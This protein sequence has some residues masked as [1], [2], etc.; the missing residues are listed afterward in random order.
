MENIHEAVAQF[1]F[2]LGVVRSGVLHA[3]LAP[4]DIVCVL[5][6]QRRDRPETAG[7]HETDGL[8]KDRW[9]GEMCYSK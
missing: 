6:L 8:S 3:A 4:L 9:P 2:S 7:N 5:T 1:L